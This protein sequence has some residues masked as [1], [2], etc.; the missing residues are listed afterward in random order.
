MIDPTFLQA[1]KDRVSL[2]E[3]IGRQVTLTRRGREHVGLCPFHSEK[4][5]S[6]TVNEQKGFYHCFG[7]GAH[8]GP[9]DFLMAA[10]NLSFPEAVERLAAAVGMRMPAPDPRAAQAERRRASLQDAV[11]A[12]AKWF[13]AQLQGAGG[14]AAR[15]YLEQRGVRT[16]TA[17]RFRLGL[18]PDRR[19]GLRDALLARDLPEALL[20]E[21]GLLVRPEQGG[22]CHDRF[23]NRLIFPISDRRGRAIAFGGRALGEARAKYLNSPETPLFHKGATLYNYANARQAAVESGRIVVVEGYMDVIA[24][25]QAGFSDAVAPLGTAVTEDQLQLL[26]RAAPSPILC[27]DGDAAGVRAAARALERALPLMTPQRTLSFAL[28]PQGQDPDDLVRMAGRDGLARLLEAALP[29]SEMVWRIACTTHPPDSPESAARRNEAALQLVDR[30]GEANLKGSLKDSMWE[31][32]RA[33]RAERRP[34]RH[35]RGRGGKG[36]G[37]AADSVLVPMAAPD[38]TRRERRLLALAL[39]R[40]DLV[41]AELEAFAAV[42]FL[43]LQLDSLKRAII[44]ATS[45]EAALDAGGL[46]DHLCATGH[47]A[48]LRRLENGDLKGPGSAGDTTGQ[49]LEKAWRE[50]M[51]LFSLR[52]SAQAVPRGVQAL[53]EAGNAE[54]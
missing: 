11:E 3:L 51:D 49:E 21:A 53:R 30:I 54:R 23:R 16:E 27:F 10:E 12:A 2:A 19:T 15:T 52:I 24:L 20:V 35:G 50:T 28:L 26:W 31:R 9:V 43:D 29:V 46:W 44:D 39:A 18:A 40:P 22:D 42:P 38:K 32:I 47:D 36:R 14:G 7:C 33:E 25:V 48:A 13:S 6:F 5:P 1:L 34:G 17:A 37:A 4:T 45:R 41:L 8:G